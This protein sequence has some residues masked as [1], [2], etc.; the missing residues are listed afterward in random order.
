VYA[1]LGALSLKKQCQFYGVVENYKTIAHHFEEARVTRKRTNPLQ[2]S[3]LKRN[4]IP[5]NKEWWE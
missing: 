4:S 2:Q 5:N 3:K 1:G